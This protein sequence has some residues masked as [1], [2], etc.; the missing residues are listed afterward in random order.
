[1]TKNSLLFVF[2]AFYL[3]I[4]GISTQNLNSEVSYRFIQ[5]EFEGLSDEEMLRAGALPIYFGMGYNTILG[6][7]LHIEK[8]D[9][10]FTQTMFKYSYSKGQKTE[11]GK[12][13]I[14]DHVNEVRTTSCS[15]NSAT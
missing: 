11:D 9:P 8:V 5:N 3:A 4:I 6:N 7:P 13:L 14:P 15:Y 1:M 12:Y 2:L 10:G